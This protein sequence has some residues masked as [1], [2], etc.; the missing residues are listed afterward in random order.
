MTCTGLVEGKTVIWPVFWPESG[1]S[2]GV[3][4]PRGLAEGAHHDCYGLG[5]HSSSRSARSRLRRKLQIA[6]VALAIAVATLT[7]LIVLQLF[8]T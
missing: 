5:V 2:C 6:V 7:V 3:R 1:I 8:G 4:A